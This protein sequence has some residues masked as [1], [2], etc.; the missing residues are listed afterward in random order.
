MRAEYD[1]P[2]SRALRVYAGVQFLALLALG[3]HFLQNAGAFAPWL[4]GVYALFLIAGLVSIGGLLE[5][6]A[7]APLLESMRLLAFG[8]APATLGFLPGLPELPLGTRGLVPLLVV[9]MVLWLWA[10]WRSRD[11]APALGAGVAAT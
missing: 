9:P 4:R 10:A 2:V 7:W 6:R 11:R 5:R 8:I 3:T 1:P